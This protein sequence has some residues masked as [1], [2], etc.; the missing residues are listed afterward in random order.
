M[1]INNAPASDNRDVLKEIA[2]R[3]MA[4]RGLEPDFT[5]QATAQLNGI[6]KPA[7][8][9]GGDVKDLRA[10]LWCSIDNDDSRD[11]DQISVAEAM[12]GGLTKILIA[13]AD[14]DAVVTKGSPIDAHARTNTTS[15]YTAA[16][17]FWMLPPKLCTDLT[18]LNE[19]Q[20]RLALVMELHVAENGQVMDSLVYR[21]MVRNRAK[22]AYNSVAAWL[23]GKGAM[24]ARIGQVPGLEA[25]LRLQ[26]RVAQSMKEMRHS[27]GALV[28]ETLQTH[29]VFTGDTLSDLC[30]DEKNRA[31]ELI[32]DF[33]IGANTAVAKFLVAKGIPSLRR[34]LQ[35]P[36]RWDRIVELA[37]RLGEQLPVEPDST[38]LARFLAI[39]QK[40]DPARFPDLSLSVVKLLGKG[41]YIVEVPGQ[42]IEG[43]FA[44]AVRDYT[45]STAPNRRYPDVITHRLLKS[46]L[47]GGGSPYS[48]DD[49][50][51][52][53]QHCTEQEDNAARVE[54]QVSKSAAALL[55]AS[56]V[57]EKFD[58]IVTAASEQGTWVRILRPPI[59]G[60]LARGASGA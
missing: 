12:T 13:V 20:D 38:A 25:N 43:H 35:K 22:L 44:L 54:R 42:K 3:A 5:P 23:D 34:V 56:R 16:E 59:E 47:Q 11:L 39:R 41:E 51:A 27:H 7:A 33:M 8:E 28:L 48:Q 14:V 15:V 1:P 53:A 24:P 46:A 18:S 58:A 17:V 9:S 21:A 45:H 49:L 50:R 10:L 37:R 30:P 2:H 52:L 57:G 19:E 31:K 36:H 26:D 40:K 55:L 32:E 4:S 29:A 6:T 60:K